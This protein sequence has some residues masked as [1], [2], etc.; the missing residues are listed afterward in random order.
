MLTPSPRLKRIMSKYKIFFLPT[1]IQFAVRPQNKIFWNLF[2]S[3]LLV[4]AVLVHHS[5]HSIHTVLFIS[6]WKDIYKVSFFSNIGI[7]FLEHLW[8]HSILLYP[9]SLLV[10]SFNIQLSKCYLVCPELFRFF[11]KPFDSSS[12]TLNHWLVHIKANP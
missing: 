6:I 10:V 3:S 11:E 5:R 9:F 7:D 12:S 1:I 2:L 4:H 8:R